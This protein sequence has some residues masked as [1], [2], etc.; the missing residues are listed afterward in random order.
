[1]PTVTKAK[2]L[3]VLGYRI[4]LLRTER[5]WSQERLAERA[6]VHVNYLGEVE[7]G[8]RNPAIWNVS[9]I[10]RA[11]GMSLAELFEDVA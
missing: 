2:L 10:A 11:L 7:R 6:Q 9:R 3:K 5:G 1:M 4:R 8:Q